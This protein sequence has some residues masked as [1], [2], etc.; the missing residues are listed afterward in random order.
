VRRPPAAA[1]V[2][3]RVTATIR[4]HELVVAGST[5][6]VAVSGGPDSVCLLESLVRLR[7]LFHLRL[8]VGHVDHGLRP[9]SGRDAAYV[10]RL[11]ARHGL[12]AHVFTVREAP[13]A[14]ASVEAWARA[15]RRRWLI[16]TARAA[17]A[18]RIALGHTLDDQAETVLL[19][20]LTG[21]GLNGLAGIAPIEG[22]WVNPLLDVTRSEVEACCRSLGLR[23]RRDATNEDLRHPRNALRH[24]GI[25]ALERIMGRA[26]IE[27]LARTADALR[28][29]A[30]ELARQAAAAGAEVMD[31]TPTG[32]NL[33][34]DAL[35]GLPRA[36]GTRIVTHAVY[37]CGAVCTQADVE[38]VL[39]LAGGRPGRRR[40]LSDG[41]R[42]RRGPEHVHLQR[43]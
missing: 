7:R 39:D 35:L 36:L 4:R 9:S 12:E 15:D 33:A 19:N 32:V 1:R 34:A 18:E 40:D 23:P 14:G 37:R 27:P 42:A 20:L 38:A 24:E 10:R 11:A 5:V 3:E 6:V 16:R 17:G 8:L 41:L 21:S 30:H 26:L 28:P 29:D 25:P 43:G 22:P 2:L 13:P 31:E